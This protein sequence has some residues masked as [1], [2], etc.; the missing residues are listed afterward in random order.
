[1]KAN[2]DK[3]CVTD[4]NESD[5]DECSKEVKVVP[6]EDQFDFS[7]RLQSVS[8][9]CFK[10]EK[11]PPHLYFYVEA[12]SICG[13]SNRQQ[14]LASFD[15]PFKLLVGG[16]VYTLCVRGFWSARH[17]WCKVLKSVGGM[18]GVWLHNDLK[19]QGN[20]QMINTVPGSIGG[21][22]Y[23]TSYVMYSQSWNNEEESLIDKSVKQIMAEHP[24]AEGVVPFVGMKSLLCDCSN[25]PN[26]LED[27]LKVVG[28]D[29]ESEDPDQNNNALPNKS[30]TWKSSDTESSCNRSS[31][32]LSPLDK[33]D[34]LSKIS[35]VVPSENITQVTQDP[36][37]KPGAPDLDDD[38]A[39][40][41]TNTKATSDSN[42]VA[43]AP[44]EFKVRL[45]LNPVAK[46]VRGRGRP[47]GR[48]RGQGGSA[49]RKLARKTGSSKD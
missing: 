25:K 48:G 37:V 41:D 26:D 3:Q 19:N 13:S 17:Y 36:C 22:E 4:D 14:Y 38:I 42:K 33:D 29:P 34:I 18:V 39:N 49:T 2:K 32:N 7:S 9:L 45:K 12:N 1:V 16:V 40:V 20:A 11:P 24:N 31:A 30:S 28:P 21:K 47:R 8:H 23:A 15:W 6:K 35:T 27:P 5:S 43:P 46:S 10:D 44:S